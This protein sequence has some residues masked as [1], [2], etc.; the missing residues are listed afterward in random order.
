MANIS[1]AQ[2]FRAQQVGA[3]VTTLY[4]VPAN[5]T[6]QIKKLTFANPTGTTRTLSVYLLVGS[7]AADDS[8]VLVKSRT[9]AP[10]ETF[11]CYMAQGHVLPAGGT[12]VASADQLGAIVAV[13]SGLLVQ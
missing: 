7:Q 12:I 4:T 13:G 3:A 11:E 6:C 2:L 9:V 8:S 10:N 1:A 5:T